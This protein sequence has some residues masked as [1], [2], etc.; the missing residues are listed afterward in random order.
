MNSR[1]KASEIIRERLSEQRDE[2][3]ALFQRRIINNIPPE[4]IMGVRTP[5][6]RSMA[7]EIF[8][9][10][11]DPELCEDFLNA[12]P[13]RYFEENQLHSFILCLEKDYDRCIEKVDAFLPFV[14]N[15]ATCDQLAPKVFGKNTDRLA[16]DIDRWLSSDEPYTIRFG[17]EMMMSHYLDEL[18]DVSF[19]EKAAV[20]RSEEYYVNMMT[21]W[22][23]ATA[24][25]KQYDSTLPFIE[26][27]RLD[28]WTHN[29]S[30]QKAV[31]SRR[32]TPEQK[33]YLR[34]LKIGG[35]GGKR[36]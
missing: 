29:K 17:I 26:Q 32:I 1:D 16:A 25:A 24:L 6:L 3:Y 27:H 33:D 22:F 4:T 5:A 31:E 14:D 2:E 10:K 20:I 13:H 23:F 21:A 12:L 36:K 30:I 9:D 18:F 19:L 7:K 28:E 35:R 34:T 15:W 8:R 11:N